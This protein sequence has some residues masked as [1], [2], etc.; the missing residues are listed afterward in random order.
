MNVT[1]ISATV[2]VVAEERGLTPGDVFV[3]VTE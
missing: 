2:T 1:L 3:G